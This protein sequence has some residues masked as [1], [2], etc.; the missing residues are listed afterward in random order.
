MNSEFESNIISIQ[1]PVLDLLPERIFWKDANSVYMGCNLAFARDAQLECSA[2][3]I[4]KTDFDLPWK[5]TEAEAYRADDRQVMTTLEPKLKFEERQTRED[6]WVDW[7]E[8]SK[9]PIFDE[10]GAL[11]GVLGTYTFITDRKQEEFRLRDARTAAESA[12]RRQ[13]EFLAT[14]SH[15]IRTPLNV[16][17]GYI[18]LLQSGGDTAINPEMIYE[19]MASSGKSLREL[20]DDVLDLSSIEAGKVTTNIEPFNIHDLLKIQIQ[21]MERLAQEKGLSLNLD[22]CSKTPTHIKS[23]PK[24]LGQVVRNL[25]SNAIKFTWQGSVSMDVTCDTD[26]SNECR[27]SLKVSDTGIGIHPE[28][29]SQLF[30]KYVRV[31]H[32][33]SRRN[34]GTGLGLYTSRCLC[35][36]LGGDLTMASTYSEGSE[37]IASIIC[38]VASIDVEPSKEK[39]NKNEDRKLAEIYPMEILIV[40]DIKANRD[41]AK[42]F[43]SNMGYQCTSFSSGLEAID[44]LDQEGA[45][46]VLMDVEMPEFSGLDA[47]RKIREEKFRQNRS[48][49]SPLT[50]I[51]LTA[52]VLPEEKQKCF[53]AGMDG[54][55]AKPLSLLDLKSALIKLESG[56]V[57]N[58]PSAPVEAEM[59]S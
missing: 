20:I 50:V 36:H 31:D 26:S 4:G 54:Y 15:E 10:G 53:D 14:M 46:L 2:D 9:Q 44:Y 17:L 12:K 7:L 30:E 49:E 11:I 25:L 6:G 24:L 41:L 34:S 33:H 1:Q 48:P 23:D 42:A 13:A 21:N 40:D 38:E 29:A 37:F 28:D 55:L 58:A 19:I 5:E 27:I 35:R 18:E 32:S 45:D 16:I 47:T 43:L 3:I 59:L 57:V 22:I 52:G 39:S 56:H 8:T 51:A